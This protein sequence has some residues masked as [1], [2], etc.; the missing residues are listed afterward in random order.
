M[1]QNI[2]R[3]QT[4]CNSDAQGSNCIL[5]NKYSTASIADQAQCPL[6]YTALPRISFRFRVILTVERAGSTNV[7]EGWITARMG[8]MNP[9]FAFKCASRSR[10]GNSANANRKRGVRLIING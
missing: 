3:Q 6:P 4:Y 10:S 8:S 5:L 7:P 1:I 2:Y 9:K